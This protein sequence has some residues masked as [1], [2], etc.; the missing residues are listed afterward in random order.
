MTD[1]KSSHGLWR[2]ELKTGWLISKKFPLK[3]LEQIILQEA[4]MKGPL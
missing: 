2:G 1:A 4:S 3:P